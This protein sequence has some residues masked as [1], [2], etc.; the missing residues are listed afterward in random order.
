[1]NQ[2]AV[3]IQKC[4][5]ENARVILNQME[6]QERYEGLAMRF[7]TAKARL[8][9]VS[10]LVSGKKARGELVEAFIVALGRQDGLITEFDERLWFS[11]VNFVTVY[12]KDDVRFVISD[13]QIK[14]HI[15]RIVDA[16]QP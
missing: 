12:G 10:E 14:I 5:G 9:E 13:D 3:L 7:D 4:I 15:Q 1:M 11:F 2:T 8:E 6:Y 16:I